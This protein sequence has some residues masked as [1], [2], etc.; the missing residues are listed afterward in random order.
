MRQCMLVGLAALAFLPAAVKAQG[1]LVVQQNKC[2]LEKQEQIRQMSD[3]MWL[4]VAQELVNE[5]KL[6]GAGSAY[7]AWGDEWNVVFWY[8]ASD[9]NSFHTAFADMVRRVNQRHPTFFST[10]FTWCSEHKDNIYSMAKST[11]PAATARRP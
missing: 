4:P 3:S 11:V 6:L 9:L 7:H 5:G 1:T 2:A 8:T 10:A